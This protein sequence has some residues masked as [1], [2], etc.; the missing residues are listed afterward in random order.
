MALVV[1]GFINLNQNLKPRTKS[2]RIGSVKT[3]LDTIALFR[4]DNTPHKTLLMTSDVKKKYKLLPKAG[5]SKS[6]VYNNEEIRHLIELHRKSTIK[7]SQSQDAK[8]V[9]IES[10]KRKI[11]ELEK[12]ILSL[13]KD[14]TWKSKHDKLIAENKELKLQ[15]EKAYKY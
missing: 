6:F 9:I 12:E 1:S 8:D 3:F 15:L 7:K 13:K 4:W 5:V 10:Q 14:E 11:K 2:S